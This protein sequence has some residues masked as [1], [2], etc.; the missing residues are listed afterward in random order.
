M[1]KNKEYHD[2]IQ[3]DLEA[4]LKKQKEKNPLKT[5]LLLINIRKVE[6]EVPK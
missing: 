6:M 3:K 5:E 1:D 4:L 2:Q